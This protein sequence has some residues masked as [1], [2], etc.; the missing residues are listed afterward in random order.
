[1]TSDQTWA[2]L[3]GQDGAEE[4][5]SAFKDGPALWVNGTEIAH[6]DDERVI[7]IRLTRALIRARRAELGEDHRVR[8]RPSSTADWIAVE[9]SDPADELFV[10]ALVQEAANAHRSA[11]RTTSRSAPTGEALERRRRFH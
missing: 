2:S 7:D 11:P 3:I 9:V 1:M 6:H 10:L 4:S 5:P 8:L